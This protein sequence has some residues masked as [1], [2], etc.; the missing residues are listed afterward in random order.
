VSKVTV[1]YTRY[2]SDMQR[3]ASCEDQEREV[4][5]GLDR[6]GLDAPNAVVIH[7]RAESGRKTNRS[8][9][10]RLGMMIRRAEVGV[11]AVDDQSRLS[12][13]DNVFDFIKDLVY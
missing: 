4:R 9:F 12:R 6:K 10:D 1:F 5:R 2:S 3:Q 8:E 11:V 13:A 7:D